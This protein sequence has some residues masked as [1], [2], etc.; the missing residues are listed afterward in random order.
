ML[1]EIGK[2]EGD[3]GRGCYVRSNRYGKNG[4]D[5]ERMGKKWE[6]KQTFSVV[7]VERKA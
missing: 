2:K 5:M 4:T 3:L 6:N 7:H 1:V